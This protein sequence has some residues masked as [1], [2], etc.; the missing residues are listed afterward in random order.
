MEVTL[1]LSFVL[2]RLCNSRKY[3]IVENFLL[4]IHF[5][6]QKPNINKNSNQK[7]Q[8]IAVFNGIIKVVMIK[9]LP[10]FFNIVWFPS[11]DA[12]RF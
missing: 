12:F 3:I 2:L 8:N 5:L 4:S 1:K 9:N 7:F 6:Y 11:R 10:K